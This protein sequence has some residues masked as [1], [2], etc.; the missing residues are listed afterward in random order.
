MSCADTFF[1][2]TNSTLKFLRNQKIKREIY[3]A[4]NL[5]H[6][7]CAINGRFFRR[8]TAVKGFGIS[9]AISQP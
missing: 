4:I 3:F 9:Y 1:I 5:F 8:K 2:Y 6:V 7:I